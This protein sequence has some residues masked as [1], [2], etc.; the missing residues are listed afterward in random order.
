MTV[1]FIGCGGGSATGLV[2]ADEGGGFVLDEGFVF[3]EWDEAFELGAVPPGSYRIE[4]VG[5]GF[6]AAA[7]VTV[8]VADGKT[9]E[10]V[11]RLDPVPLREIVVTSRV[12][13]RALLRLT[14]DCWLAI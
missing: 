5:E 12:S 1:E 3:D 2:L 7:R 4:A 13:I 10:V 14:Q 6:A 8:A 11:F 9:T